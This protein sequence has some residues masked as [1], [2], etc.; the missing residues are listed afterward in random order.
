MRNI[1][2]I[3]RTML[4]FNNDLY[5]T[6]EWVS[7]EL[8]DQLK[9][10]GFKFHWGRADCHNGCQACFAGLKEKVWWTIS[11]Q[12]AAKFE[13][14]EYAAEAI[15][16]AKASI[17]SSTKSA[18]VG[19]PETFF[20]LAPQGLSY[21]PYQK[22]AIEYA[23]KRR[24]VLFA[25]EMGL[26]KTIEVLGFANYINARSLLIV[27]P[28]S[29]KELW[30]HEVRRWLLSKLS[31]HVVYDTNTITKSDILIVNYERFAID[32]SAELIEHISSRLWDLVIFD[33]AHKLKNPKAKR[34]IAI[35]GEPNKG[36]TGIVKPESRVAMLTGTPM[37]NRPREMFGLLQALDPET[38][39]NQW[40]F[41]QRYCGA[42]KKKIW[43]KDEN[44]K[45]EE[46]EVW[47]FDGASNLEELQAIMR[48][49][50]MIRRLKKHVMRELPAKV[51]QLIAIRGTCFDEVLNEMQT[52]MEFAPNMVKLRV[53]VMQAEL[54]GRSEDY[55][56][57]VAKLH[58]AQSHIAFHKLSEHRHKLAL[59]KVPYA[60]S[61]INELLDGGVKK[62]IVFAHHRAVLE[63]IAESYKDT[64]VVLHGQIP[65]EQRMDLVK[66]FQEDPKIK[67]FIGSI[68]AS[69]TGITLTAAHHELFVEADW[70]PSNLLQAED[71]AH[72]VGQLN[73]VLV[74]HLVVDRS[75]EVYM[76]Q[77]VIQ[78]MRTIEAATNITALVGWLY[79]REPST[80]RM[81]KVRVETMDTKRRVSVLIQLLSSACKDSKEVDPAHKQIAHT[82]A[83]LSIENWLTDRQTYSAKKLIRAYEH[84]LPADVIG[85]VFPA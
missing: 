3:L 45:A 74:Q 50:F 72:R 43:G 55:M 15:A 31:I 81:L 75:L 22:A 71:R 78:K 39:S 58:T 28:A 32:G 35:L 54:A 25:D 8:K 9:A 53:E 66:R 52:A 20:A 33:E 47:D 27:C 7:V 70:V 38:F 79:T 5:H 10:A 44:G 40:N 67:L 6:I 80:G 84:M 57:A 36:N 21:F 12:A 63:G 64:S 14:D 46:K 1:R 65:P 68:Q 83:D 62:L 59:L 42:K 82:I 13:H 77:R 41:Q 17:H 51:R 18:P 11:H 16:Q 26:G 49:K 23:R 56:K 29:L 76:L 34:T 24:R 69:G 2:G 30:R 19:K 73:S 60:V 4:T 61:H 85:K 48:D 37:M